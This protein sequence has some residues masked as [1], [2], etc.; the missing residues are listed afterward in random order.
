MKGMPTRHGIPL[1]VLRFLEGNTLNVTIPQVGNSRGIL[2]PKPMLR[3]LGLEDAAEITLEGDAIVLRKP[4]RQ[5]REGWAD[6]AK[7]IG[8]DADDG[9]VMGSLANEGDQELVW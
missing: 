3:Q 6:A 5:P 1:P 7:L 4:R 2:I 8:D 9:L